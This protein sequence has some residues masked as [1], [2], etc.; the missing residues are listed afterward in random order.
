[1]VPAA[2]GTGSATRLRDILAGEGVDVGPGEPVPGA[3][4]VVV[5][6]IDRGVVLPGAPLA[7]VAEA[8]LTGRRRVHRRARGARRG[9]DHYDALE[10]GDYVVHHQHSVGRYLEM[11]P[12]TMGGVERDYLWLEF[13][14]GK[15]YVPT[16]QVGFVRKYTGGGTPSL[17]PMARAARRS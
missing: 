12:L 13:K 14:D 15:V 2:E 7:L 3:V 11:K 8:D 9:Q 5:A 16:D 1:G 4:R 6:P 10:P 17:N